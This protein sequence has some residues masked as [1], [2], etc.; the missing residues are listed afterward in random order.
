LLARIG[1][2]VA[3]RESESARRHGRRRGRRWARRGAVPPGACRAALREGLPLRR[4]RMARMA[5]LGC[6]CSSTASVR[7]HI[8]GFESRQ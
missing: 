5:W 8:D 4:R 1:A 7:V 3:R 6:S 2:D